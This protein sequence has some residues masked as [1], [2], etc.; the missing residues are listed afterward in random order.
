MGSPL[1]SL[2][3]V[4]ILI[5]IYASSYL[6]LNILEGLKII[7]VILT[8][9]LSISGGY[10][11]SISIVGISLF[12]VIGLIISKTITLR[13][14]KEYELTQAK[15]Y[16]ENI[17]AS[18]IDTLIVVNPDT[19]IRTVN[20]ATLDLLGYTQEEL[21]GKVVT[22][23]FTEEEEEGLFK[24]TRLKKLIE[25]G[26]VRDFKMTYKTKSGEKIP[27]SFFGSVMYEK[28]ACSVERIGGDK[29]SA[30]KRMV[31]SMVEGVVMVDELGEVVVANPR[32]R[33]LLSLGF[34]KQVTTKI[35]EEKISSL[36]LEESLKECRANNCLVS[37]DLVVSLRGEPVFLRCD[38]ARQKTKKVKLSA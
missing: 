29:L 28:I 27:M 37:K 35:W 16:T 5:A 30:M 15:D 38:M 32:V 21:I 2:K 13:R 10:F 3:R 12:V 31:E 20:K 14:E 34:E 4:V 7:P 26:S 22:L 36:G 23:I 33:Q 6:S 9:G 25:E 17:I 18:I 8:P 11:W 1:F 24:E 19:T